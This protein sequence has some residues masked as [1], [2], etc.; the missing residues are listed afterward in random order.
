VANSPRLTSLS[1]SFT[2]SLARLPGYCGAPRR[3]SAEE[4]HALAHLV[5]REDAGVEAV[6]EIGGEVGDLVGQVDELGFER[7]ELVEEVFA[8]SG[9]S[10]AE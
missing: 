3:G 9:W 8:S 7:R 2:A 1:S 10:A 6:V 4:R 5:E